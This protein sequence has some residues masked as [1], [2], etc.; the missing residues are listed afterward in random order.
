MQTKICINN[1]KHFYIFEQVQMTS[2]QICVLIFF[3]LPNSE[4]YTKFIPPK[5]KQV[6]AD[7]FQLIIPEQMPLNHSGL[8]KS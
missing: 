2:K 1:T 4:L 6:D 7:Q 3:F 8:Q 5:F